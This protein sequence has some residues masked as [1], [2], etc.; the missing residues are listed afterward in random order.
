MRA[1]IEP[2]LRS[3]SIFLAA[4]FALVAASG[5][6]AA[7]P[8]PELRLPPGTHR[9]AQGELVSGRGLR[10]TS[11]F[12]ATELRRRGI[13]TQQIGPY[14]VRSV[15]LTRFISRTEQTPWLAIHVLRQSGKTVIFFVPRAKSS[16]TP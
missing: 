5:P 7:D 6:A 3:A 13:D 12:L 10:E 15:E 9:N 2:R 8:Q 1:S 11:D 4:W 14:G 16:T